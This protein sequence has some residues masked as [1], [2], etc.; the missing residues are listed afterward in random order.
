[1][2][3]IFQN[4]GEVSSRPFTFLD[5]LDTGVWTSILLTTFVVG[6][7]VSLANKLSPNDYHGE[8]IYVDKDLKEAR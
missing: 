5:P 8:F 6:V 3:P 7:W 2:T 4:E 1:M